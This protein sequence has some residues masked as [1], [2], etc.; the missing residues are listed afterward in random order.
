MRK[1]TQCDSIK[2]K[3]GFLSFC[4]KSQIP[5]Q[6]EISLFTLLDRKMGCVKLEK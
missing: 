6:N 4:Q 2:D 1:N 5:S 3:R